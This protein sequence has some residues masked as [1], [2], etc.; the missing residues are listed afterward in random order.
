METYKIVRMYRDENKRSRTMKRGLSLKEAQYHC[1]L[2]STRKEGEW[3]DG[4]DLE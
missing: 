4:Y 3:F 1:S 2:E